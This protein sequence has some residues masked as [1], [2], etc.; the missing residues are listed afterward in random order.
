MCGRYLMTAPVEAVRRLFEAAGAPNLPAR[1]NIAPTQEAPVVRLSDGARELA[2]L[3]WGLVP[4]WA[5]DLSVGSRMIN[6]RSETAAVKP[7]FRDAFSSRRCLVPANGFY[8]WAPQGKAKQ[9]WLARLPDG[10]LYGFAGLWERWTP[11]GGGAAVETFT[12]LT[13]EA[14]EALRPLHPRMPVM[15]A[16]AD[17]ETWLAGDPAAAQALLK[18]WT[19]PIETV[20]VGPR[21][22]SPRFDDADCIRPLVEEEMVEEN[23]APPPDGKAGQMRLL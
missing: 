10:A 2:M 9:P 18:P 17:Y 16:P 13:T 20:K 14:N 12:I 4:P 1:Y 15:V 6:A 8:E 23:G 5:A 7:A 19:G 11:K 22:N 3:R 21:V